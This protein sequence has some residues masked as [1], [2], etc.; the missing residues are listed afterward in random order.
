MVLI[1]IFN[2]ILDTF[3]CIRRRKVK[4]KLTYIVNINRTKQNH[5]TVGDSTNI[6]QSLSTVANSLSGD[7][8]S[9]VQC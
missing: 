9:A 4:T 1:F 3:S 2:S 5:D 8:Q 6:P 7:T